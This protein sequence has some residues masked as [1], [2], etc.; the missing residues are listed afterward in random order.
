MVSAEAQSDL[1]YDVAAMRTYAA[2]LVAFWRELKDG[3]MSEHD[4][5]ECVLELIRSISFANR[6]DA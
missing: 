4:A 5:L 3:G 1:R 2:N 6:T